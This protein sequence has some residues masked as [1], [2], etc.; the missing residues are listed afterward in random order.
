MPAPDIRRRSGSRCGGQPGRLSETSPAAVRSSGRRCARRQEIGHAAAL[1]ARG[2]ARSRRI[3]SALDGV[4]LAR[5]FLSRMPEQLSGGQRQRVAIARA[6]VLEPRLVLLDEPVS[7]LDVSI[8]A[9]VLN[10][11]S[12]LRRDRGLSYVVVSHDLSTL[13]FLA[14]RIGVMFEGR[15]VESAATADLVRSPSH[16][17]TRR[18]LAAVPSIA[19]S[20][21]NRA[22]SLS[23]RA[24]PSSS[25]IEGD[26]HV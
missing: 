7:A 12:D 26:A 5:L 19:K 3:E 24:G 4:G 10:L 15:I 6:L 11:L 17:Y 14:E 1:A 21:S 18:L 2:A 25:Q 8:R 22:K 13:R 16:D 9:Q 23:S 20:L